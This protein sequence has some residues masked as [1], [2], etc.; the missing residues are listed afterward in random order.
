MIDKLLAYKDRPRNIRKEIIGRLYSKPFV[1]LLVSPFFKSTT[2]KNWIFI[3]GC[4]NSGTTILREILGAH[5][6]ISGLPKEGVRFTKEFGRPEDLGW[7]RNWIYCQDYIHLKP[8]LDSNKSSKLIRDWSPL[9]DRSKSHFLE[10]SISNIERMEWIDVNLDN[11]Y[12]IGIIRNGFAVVDGIRRKAKP[13]GPAIDQYGATEY[14]VKT[15]ASQWLMANQNMLKYSKKVK[16]FLQIE[17]ERFADD[18]KGVIDEICQFL[19]ITNAYT[20]IGNTIKISDAEF[21]VRNMNEKSINRLTE[22]EISVIESTAGS[23]LSKFNY[24]GK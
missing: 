9:W 19:K 7:T 3:V 11:V 6:S 13:K 5:P 15:A 1:R 24:T 21:T 12:F 14:S 18:P 10:K 20:T 2:P 17:Y 4:Y 8:G 16:N 23:L 22:E